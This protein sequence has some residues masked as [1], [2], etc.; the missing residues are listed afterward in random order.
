MRKG[1]KD[2]ADAMEGSTMGEKRRATNVRPTSA[3]GVKSVSSEVVGEPPEVVEKR[4]QET[5]HDSAQKSEDIQKTD[6][7]AGRE[8][9]WRLLEL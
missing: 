7:S 8:D 2:G 3:P 5:D 4:R 1:T 9:I 6:E